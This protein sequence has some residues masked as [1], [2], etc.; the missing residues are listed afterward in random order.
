VRVFLEIGVWSFFGAWDLGLEFPRGEPRGPS[1]YRDIEI[2]LPKLFII[3]RIF[4]PAHKSLVK[5]RLGLCQNWWHGHCN[6]AV[7]QPNYL[8][9]SR[10]NDA[11]H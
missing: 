9:P 4:V 7:A 11:S 2:P 8:N 3:A 6:R 1:H 10:P 5:C